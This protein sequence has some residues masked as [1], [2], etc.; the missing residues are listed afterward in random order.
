MTMDTILE[1][2]LALI[3]D[4]D[5]L[6]EVDPAWAEALAGH[7]REQG[8]RIKG[9]GLQTPV[10]VREAGPDGRHKLVF[11]AH[12]VAACR[13]LEWGSIPARVF[14]GSDLEARLAEI[15]ENLV[16]RELGPLERAIFLA[17]RK[18]VYLEMHPQA[19]GGKAGA[20][21]RFHAKEIISFASSVAKKIGL[22]ERAINFDIAIAEALAAD[23]RH[24]LQEE[25]LGLKQK[26]LLRLAALPH[27]R[28]RE[29]VEAVAAL[30]GRGFASA[31]SS[32]EG[33]KLPVVASEEKQ[34]RALLAAWEKNT[35][36]RARSRFLAQIAPRKAVAA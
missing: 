31:V 8:K 10:E 26:E 24:A 13:L 16:R 17:E 27:A 12:R 11:G 35:N 25:R 28:Q 3:D 6:R 4:T 18:R 23:V 36:P 14:S 9:R 5:R 2:P 22:T 33:A 30:G 21:K 29:V 1:I 7:I 19:A 32:V 34:F 15:D 20:N